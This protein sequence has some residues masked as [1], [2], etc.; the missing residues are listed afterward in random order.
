MRT[1]LLTTLV[2]AVGLAACGSGT[3][4]TTSSSSSSSESTTTTTI[5]STEAAAVAAAVNLKAAD[6]PGYNGFPHTN[7]P[8]RQQTRD[9]VAQCAGATRPSS[10]VADMYSP[11]FVGGSV[12][13]IRVVGSDVRAIPTAG[14]VRTDL[15]ANKGPKAQ[16]CFSQFASSL[17]S[18]SVGPSVHIISLATQDLSA[19]APGTEGAFG[20]RF[21][22]NATLQGKPL[23]VDIDILGFPQGNYEVELDAF[24]IG[25]AFPSA[26]EQQLFSLLVNR[27]KSTVH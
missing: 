20:Y 11:D 19:S 5:T 8:Q 10:A 14:M 4:P 13:Q 24:A 6:V 23:T 15:V 9:Q 25:Q 2:A 7:T 3:S 18:Q 16:Q 27:A 12:P 22:V 1:G 26:T 17:V 21:V